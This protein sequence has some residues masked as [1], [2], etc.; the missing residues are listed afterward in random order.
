MRTVCFDTASDYYHN[1]LLGYLNSPRQAREQFRGKSFKFYGATAFVHETDQ[2][3]DF[4]SYKDLFDFLIEADEIV[5]FNGRTCDLIVLESLIGEDVFEKIWTKRHHDL[6]GWRA[7]SLD[8]SVGS[9]PELKRSYD[10]L[11]ESRYAERGVISNEF[12]RH[13]LAGTH[14]DSKCTLELYRLYLA[15]GDRSCT[16]CDSEMSE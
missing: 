1:S 6:K 8:L 2:S 4:Q 12:I 13:H 7:Q 5:T 16:F 9:I 3:S 11:Y 14:R 10:S 15:N